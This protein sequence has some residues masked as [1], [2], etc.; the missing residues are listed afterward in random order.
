[1]AIIASHNTMS[2]LKPRHWWMKLFSFIYKCQDKTIRQQLLEGVRDFDIRIAVDDDFNYCFA[3]GIVKFRS[4]STDN[5]VSIFRL[6]NGKSYTERIPINVRLI[7]EEPYHTKLTE[8][9]TKRF[10]YLIYDL[11]NS[12]K[13][14]NLYEFRRKYDWK[15]LTPEFNRNVDYEQFISSMNGKWYNSWL[16]RIFAKRYNKEAVSNTDKTL[17]ID[18]VNQYN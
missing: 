1:M 2:Y 9:K 13:Y 5:I 18:F 15:N 3:H 14:I 8:E 17:F 11:L 4:T 10:I 7:F 6:L 16:P 12:Y